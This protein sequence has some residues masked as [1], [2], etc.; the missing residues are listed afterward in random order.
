MKPVR[1]EIKL[2]AVEIYKK[3]DPD[4]GKRVEEKLGLKTE[5]KL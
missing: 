4:Y 5:A 1:K 3:I 2:R